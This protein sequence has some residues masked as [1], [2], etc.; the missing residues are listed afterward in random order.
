VISI[1]H[2]RVAG[3]APIDKYIR[4]HREAPPSAMATSEFPA[5]VPPRSARLF[6]QGL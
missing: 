4:W 5:V 6:D 2:L 3:R 1:F